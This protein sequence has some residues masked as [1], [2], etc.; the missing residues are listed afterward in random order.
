[1]ETFLVATTAKT[2]VTRCFSGLVVCKCR[3]SL[4]TFCVL[5]C[6]EFH[7]CLLWIFKFELFP[8]LVLLQK[9]ISYSYDC[10]L[11]C[12]FVFL[13]TL[14]QSTVL[15]PTAPSDYMISIDECQ[16]SVIWLAVKVID[17]TVVLLLQTLKQNYRYKSGWIKMI[18]KKSQLYI[19][20]DQKLLNTCNNRTYR[21]K[22]DH[23]TSLFS[24]CVW[25]F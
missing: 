6:W 25:V 2:T 19:Q 4:N 23:L 1:M 12:W 15:T 13:G 16:N 11:S 18:A 20:P 10:C 8:T 3:L 22:K 9:D 14:S 24:T 5:T 7:P 17:I 21:N